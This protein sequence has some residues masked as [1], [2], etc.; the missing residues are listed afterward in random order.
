M[1]F[2]SIFNALACASLF[3]ATADAAEFYVSGGISQGFPNNDYVVLDEY[4]R[5]AAFQAGGGVNFDRFGD[6]NASIHA[7]ADSLADMGGLR[8]HSF[9]SI[10]KLSEQ[11]ISGVRISSGSYARAVFTDFFIEGNGATTVT[12]PVNFLLTGEQS[13]GASVATRSINSATSTVQ[14]FFRFT[15]DNLSQQSGGGFHTIQTINGEL[16]EPFE[17]GI[18]TGFDGEQLL[19]LPAVVL[20]VGSFFALEM[21][22]QTSTTLLYHFTEP[23]FTSGA[24]AAFGN[25]L[26]FAEGPVFG[27]PDGF[28]INSVSAGIVDNH[29]APVPLPATLWLLASAVIGGLGLMRRKAA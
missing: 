25:T 18:L 19:T 7:Q 21:M 4:E 26:K 20:P 14:V 6:G 29:F 11:F 5:A 3:I 8:A 2:P 28:T 17:S 9:A 10:S 12:V 23:T 1:R 24:N 27:L 13:V 22:L 15:S 16:Q